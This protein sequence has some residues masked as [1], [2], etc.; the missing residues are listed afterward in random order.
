MAREIAL[1]YAVPET[2]YPFIFLSFLKKFYFIYL[3]CVFSER[4][5]ERGKERE[6]EKHQLATPHTRPDWGPDLQPR[7]VP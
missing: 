7:H 1:D 4:G 5:E 6:R 2:V 3:S